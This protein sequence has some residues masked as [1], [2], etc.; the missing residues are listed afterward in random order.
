M[1]EHLPE[2]VCGLHRRRD[3]DGGSLRDGAHTAYGARELPLQTSSSKSRLPERRYRTPGA[4]SA[5][6]PFAVRSTPYLATEDRFIPQDLGIHIIDIARF[7]FGEVSPLSASTQRVNPNIREEDV[8]TLVVAPHLWVEPR[9]W[10]AATPR[11]SF[12]KTS[13]KH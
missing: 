10:T 7:L 2:A 13:P 4:A 6:R 8:V 1:S 5:G 3:G 9:W 12:L 11:R